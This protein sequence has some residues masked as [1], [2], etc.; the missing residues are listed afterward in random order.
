[1]ADIDLQSGGA[2]LADGDLARGGLPLAPSQA[3]R[4]LERTI[5]DY[6]PV[7][8]PTRWG[9]DLA[10]QERRVCRVELNDD[11]GTTGTGFLVGPDLVLTNYHV[12]EAVIARPQLAAAV[13]FRFDYKA[14]GDGTTSDGVLVG[15]HPTAWEIGHSPYG[16][17]EAKRTP[18][19]PPPTADELDYA[20]VRLERPIGME[21]A[22][23][24]G[25]PR[26]WVRMP[27][28]DPATADQSLFILQHPRGAPI[29][30][31]LDTHANPR[32]VNGG[33]RLRYAT[34]TDEG[35]SGSP[36][37]SSNWTLLA[38][39]H[40]GDPAWGSPDY[41]QGIPIARIRERAAAVLGGIGPPPLGPTGI[42]EIVVLPLGSRALAIAADFREDIEGVL[43][44]I[45]VLEGYKLLH[46]V[47]HKLDFG[48]LEVVKRAARHVR[49]EESERLS[50][51]A[52]TVDL[53]DLAEKAKQAARGLPSVDFETQWIDGL[54]CASESL[55]IAA[56]PG[57]VETPPVAGAAGHAATGPQ[58]E[59]ALF[60]LDRAVS[61]LPII[62]G[63][64]VAKA[65][66]LEEPLRQLIRILERQVT[67]LGAGTAGQSVAAEANRLE[68]L[69]G[70]LKRL[71]GEHDRWQSIDINLR[72]ASAKPSDLPYLWA[73]LSKAA[74]DLS[75]PYSRE[76][77]AQDLLGYARRFE[78]APAPDD[79]EQARER[80]TA[81]SLFRSLARTRF[82]AVDEEL[83]KL[84]EDLVILL[85]E[86]LKALL[87][88]IS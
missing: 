45:Q 48:M 30:L 87:K 38:L 62:N 80:R 71:V 51:L 25:S 59:E 76:R 57:S 52:Y 41:N 4:G 54:R 88:R 77:W 79:P 81:F 24:S 36:C 70:D 44:D 63:K 53:A 73:Q 19:D 7:V 58:V 23:P 8:D 5:K 83:R 69:R 85:N 56:D 33:L 37:F 27:E 21:S 11:A 20:L 10:R 34:T 28:T 42:D 3:A 67:A 68:R 55:R 2:P 46:D 16:K 50:L 26:G 35:S 17:G 13:R 65:S 61:Q 75:A 43:H 40:Y 64:L 6:L 18:D 60:R 9:E 39:H 86:P 22:N 14:I 47:L 49:G 72:Q 84:C 12:L 29:K 66:S 32:L 1:M 82:L 74:S 78:D 31:A 15:A